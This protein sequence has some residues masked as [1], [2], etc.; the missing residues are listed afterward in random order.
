MLVIGLR[1]R[2]SV[3]KLVLG[4]VAQDLLMGVACPVMAVKR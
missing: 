3:G 4:S 2:S 1:R